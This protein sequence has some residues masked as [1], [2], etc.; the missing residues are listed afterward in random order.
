MLRSP[1]SFEG[2]IGLIDSMAEGCGD[3][4]G[5]LSSKPIKATYRKEQISEEIMK[6]KKIKDNKALCE[7]I[8]KLENLSLFRGRIAFVFDCLE[9]MS[10]DVSVS[11]IDKLEQLYNIFFKHFDDGKFS[12]ELFNRA[13]LTIEVDGEYKYYDYWSSTWSAAKA[14]KRKFIKDTTDLNHCIYKEQSGGREYGKYVL[15]LIIQLLQKEYLSI[16]NDFVP[17]TDMPLWKVRLIK[18]SELIKNHGSGFFAIT[19]DNVEC[20]LLKSQKPST[21][22]GGILV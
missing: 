9:S 18:D 10:N 2:M 19:N 8:W 21:I 16:I 22:D 7:I 12:Y 6:A 13:M 14:Q 15:K 17:P 1:E 11:E 4:Y 3:I 5:F 20:Y